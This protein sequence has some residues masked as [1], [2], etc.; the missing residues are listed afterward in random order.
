MKLVLVTVA[1]AALLGGVATL[2]QAQDAT[3]I[4][5]QSADGE[6][7]K[8]IVAKADGSKT[9]VKR[10]GHYVKKVHTSPNGDKTIVKKDAE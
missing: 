3:V 9:V 2:A 6:Q 10:H 4:H 1:A 5:K 8:T 7:S